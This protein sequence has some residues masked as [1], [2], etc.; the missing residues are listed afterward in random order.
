MTIKECPS[1]GAEPKLFSE[2]IAVDTI[3]YYIKCDICQCS[4]MWSTCQNTIEKLWNTRI[5][6]TNNR[7]I[8]LNSI[9]LKPDKAI[10][11]D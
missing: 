5:L 4:T 9:K 7:F 1:C 2:P 6:L 8:E 3:Q 11:K 10:F